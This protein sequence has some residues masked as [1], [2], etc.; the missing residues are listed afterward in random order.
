MWGVFGKV[1]DMKKMWHSQ[2]SSTM[3]YNANAVKYLQKPNSQK[4]MLLI[5]GW[6]NSDSKKPIEFT[7]ILKWKFELYL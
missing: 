4:N 2:D 1:R 3:L 7:F 6:Q 5:K